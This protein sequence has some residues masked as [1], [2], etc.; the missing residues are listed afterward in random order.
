[1]DLDDASIGFAVDKVPTTPSI[2]RKGNAYVKK[3]TPVR[4]KLRHDPQQSPVG[5]IKAQRQR[6]ETY[7]S[8][9]DV[10][11]PKFFRLSTFV[12]IW[13][14][15]IFY[16]RSDRSGLVPRDNTT[17]LEE[18]Q[19]PHVASLVMSSGLVGMALT[20]WLIKPQLCSSSGMTELIISEDD[21]H[22]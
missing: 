13:S 10:R 4:Q 3:P 18:I 2:S 11:S 15:R 6:S 20:R 14:S 16:S 17:V 5:T 1:M 12:P 19:K 8:G 21:R 22:S 9:S 7:T